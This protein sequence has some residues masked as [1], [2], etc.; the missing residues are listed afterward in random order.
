M[1]EMIRTEKDRVLNVLCQ[2]MRQDRVHVSAQNGS[3]LQNVEAWAAQ[4]KKKVMETFCRRGEGNDISC[5]DEVGQRKT[6]CPCL[7]QGSSC[8]RKSRNLRCSDCSETFLKLSNDVLMSHTQKKKGR[9][10]HRTYFR[11]KAPS[12]LMICKI[13]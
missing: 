10:V 2:V 13:Q 12:K 8:N 1:E 3:V 6:K 7:I 9:E 5:R 4:T 11:G